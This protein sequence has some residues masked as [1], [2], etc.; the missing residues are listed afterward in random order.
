VAA[1]ARRAAARAPRPRRRRRAAQVWALDRREGNVTL[2]T[3]EG[4]CRDFLRGTCRRT[5]D[6]K[7]DHACAAC[8][9]PGLPRPPGLGAPPRAP[10]PPAPPAAGAP[11]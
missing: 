11:A 10:A 6:C 8:W 1:P 4:A 9:H 3:R 5:T 2:E 7:F